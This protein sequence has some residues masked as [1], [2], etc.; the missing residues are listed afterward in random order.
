MD[1]QEFRTRADEALTSLNRRLASASDEAEF[2]ADL[3]SGA[4]TIEFEDPPAKFVVSPNTPVR[5]IWVSAH[6]RSFKLDWDAARN[7]F[8]LRDTGETL[9]E[10]IQGAISKQL[11]EEVTL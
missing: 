7:A 10:L 4:L 8:V 11:G 5:Q 6:S 1:E 2:E 9:T 3:N